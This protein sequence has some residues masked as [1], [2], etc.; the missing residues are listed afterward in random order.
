MSRSRED[1][2]IGGQRVLPGETRDIALQV[3]ETSLGVPVSVPVRVL[4]GPRVGPAVFVTGAVHGDELNGTGIIRELM[5]SKLLL[6]RGTLMLVPVVNV[7]GFERHTRYLPDRR[8]LN[9]SF[10]GDPKGSLAFRLA[11][12]LY[13][14]LVERSDFGIDLHTAGQG[15]TNFAHVRADLSVPRVEQLARWFGAEVIVDRRGDEQSLR[16]VATV[17]GCLTINLE[18]GE[19]LKIEP[20]AVHIGV[21]GVLNVLKQLAMIRGKPE[22]PAYQTIVRRS[23]WVRAHAGG[24]L[25][26]HV[27]PGSIVEEGE[28]LATCDGFFREQS[29]PVRAPIAGIVLGM[30]TLPMVRPGQPIC[31]IG[32]P[33]RPPAEIVRDIA[34]SGGETLHG[35]MRA[36]LA[37]NMDVV[38]PPAA[39]R[40]TPR[41]RKAPRKP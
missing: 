23:T 10:P 30:T 16:H 9:R 27:A 33:D 36:L 8:D 21:R 31:H 28:E 1:F 32:I 6:A 40:A 12:V 3:S 39:R 29:P 38:D 17:R 22:W 35:R 7:F 14:E 37:R 2:V 20:A 11:H 18:A 15:R 5:F 4:H 13:R 34:R 26:F 41:K 19:A 24:L 25:R